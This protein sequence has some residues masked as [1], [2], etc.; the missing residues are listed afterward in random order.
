MRIASEEKDM[1]SQDFFWKYI[2][3]QVEEE[4]NATNLIE[5]VRM[6]G[7]LLSSSSTRSSLHAS[8]PVGPQTTSRQVT[9]WVLGGSSALYSD[10]SEG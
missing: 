8:N 5:R 3:E 2:R 10:R 6:L 9:R 4:A 7:V 1:P